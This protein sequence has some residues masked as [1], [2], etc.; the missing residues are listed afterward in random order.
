MCSAS[1]QPTPEPRSSAS[2]PEGHTSTSCLVPAHRASTNTPIMQFLLLSMQ[3]FSPTATAS[4]A[5]ATT[6]SHLPFQPNPFG[7]AAGQSLAHGLTPNGTGERAGQ[8]TSTFSLPEELGE[9][10]GHRRLVPSRTAGCSAIPRDAS[11]SCSAGSASPTPH[12][13]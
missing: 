6:P 10:C 3:N 5:A 12:E 11:P 9:T 4:Q 1:P 2:L 8:V 7:S 13:Y